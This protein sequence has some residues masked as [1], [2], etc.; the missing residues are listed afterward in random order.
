MT[1]DCDSTKLPRPYTRRLTRGQEADG[2]ACFAVVL[3]I[4]W[5]LFRFVIVQN[6]NMRIDNAGKGLS[7]SWGLFPLCLPSYDG[8]KAWEQG[9]LTGRCSPRPHSCSL[10]S[11]STVTHQV[12]ACV[13]SVGGCLSKCCSRSVSNTAIGW[14][15]QTATVHI[16][17][18]EKY[19]SLYDTLKGTVTITIT[20]V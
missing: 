19:T 11:E 13:T 16:C 4:K 18:R 1:V 8:V 2:T 9:T 3:F 6:S 14:I 15:S 17:Q 10:T 5:Q 20:M 12:V 7:H